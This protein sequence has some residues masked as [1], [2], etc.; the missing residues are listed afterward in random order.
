MKRQ[1]VP[2]ERNLGSIRPIALFQQIDGIAEY[3]LANAQ[4][5][6]PGVLSDAKAKLHNAA[7]RIDRIMKLTYR[8]DIT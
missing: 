3:F 7:D 1:V 6:D 5:I 8:E 4:H 2:P